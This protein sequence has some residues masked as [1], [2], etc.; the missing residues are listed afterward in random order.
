M[1]KYMRINEN[2]I[3]TIDVGLEECHFY[4][5]KREITLL[6]HLSISISLNNMMGGQL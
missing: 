1:E 2:K 6:L 5:L 4:V 3:H